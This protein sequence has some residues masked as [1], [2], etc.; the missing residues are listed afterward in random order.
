MTASSD[1][2]LRR[3]LWANAVLSVGS[4]AVLAAFAT[5]FAA[6]ATHAPL[7]VLGLDLALVLELLGLGFVAFGALCGWVASRTD[8]PIGWAR[9]IFVLDASWVAISA[10]VLMLPAAWTLAGIAGIVVVALIVADLAILEYLG[11][12]RLGTTH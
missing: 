11:L 3:T 5:P 2:L 4:G 1:R 6:M 10:V 12:R 7:Q 9:T 8:M